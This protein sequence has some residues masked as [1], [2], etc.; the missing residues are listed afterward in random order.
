MSEFVIARGGELPTFNISIKYRIPM[1][2][3][4]KADDFD[5]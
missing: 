5:F 4:R 3:E 1:M 2:G